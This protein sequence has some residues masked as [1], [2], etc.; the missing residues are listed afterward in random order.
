VA[1]TSAGVSPLLKL[2]IVNFF[3]CNDIAKM[4]VVSPIYATP[5]VRYK[6]A[7]WSPCCQ[8]VVRK[9]CGRYVA[10]LEWAS[11]DNKMLAAALRR[12]DESRVV[13]VVVFGRIFSPS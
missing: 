7:M 6:Q 10:A 3:M 11:A 13:D 9:S 8:E 12:I 2:V 1:Q 5:Y 4:K